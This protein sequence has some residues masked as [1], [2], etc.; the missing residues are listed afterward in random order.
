MALF[1]GGIILLLNIWGGKRAGS[2]ITDP[3]KEMADVHKA[4]KMLKALERRYAVL[5][6]Y[7]A[8]LILLQVAHRWTAL[9]SSNAMPLPAANMRSGISCTSL[10]K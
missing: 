2:V 9:V 8:C 1:L 7:S 5:P 3:T 4:M 6:A 10:Q